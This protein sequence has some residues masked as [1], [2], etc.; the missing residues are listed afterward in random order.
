MLVARVDA[1]YYASTIH[2]AKEFG[3]FDD[4]PIY[5]AMNDAIEERPLKG[6]A[7]LREEMLE[8]WKEFDSLAGKASY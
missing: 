7:F 6:I 5:E 8:L 1:I 4:V 2:D 3:G